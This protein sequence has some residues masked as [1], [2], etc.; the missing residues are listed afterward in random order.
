M[1]SGPPRAPV[2]I[3]A[4]CWKFLIL[5]LLT[6]IPSSLGPLGAAARTRRPFETRQ[7]VVGHR[8]R[9]FRTRTHP[10]SGPEQSGNRLGKFHFSVQNLH[11]PRIP[12]GT[13]P[14]PWEGLWAV[15]GSPNCIFLMSNCVFSW[16]GCLWRSPPGRTRGGCPRPPRNPRGRPWGPLCRD[17]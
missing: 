14:A 16:L 13:G 2:R 17:F 3:Q 15:S 5:D 1:P 12:L 11:F 10:R 8:R 6:D 7:G 9:R 4:K